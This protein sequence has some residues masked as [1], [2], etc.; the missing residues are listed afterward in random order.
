MLS[1]AFYNLALL[2]A[3]GMQQQNHPS[4]LYK[5]LWIWKQ[6]EREHWK[7]MT[8]Y[9]VCKTVGS[10]IRKQCTPSRIEPVDKWILPLRRGE[11]VTRIG[12]VQHFAHTQVA[13]GQAH[14]LG[15]MSWRFRVGSNGYDVEHPGHEVIFEF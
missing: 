14:R 10:C 4:K 8:N 11:R 6:E 7:T 9:R 3:T 2:L 5:A 12:R 1:T 15:N 13:Y